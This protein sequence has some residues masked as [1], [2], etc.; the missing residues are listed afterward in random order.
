MSKESAGL[1][2][3][4]VALIRM[5]VQDGCKTRVLLRSRRKHQG[6]IGSLGNY[7]S[8]SSSFPHLLRFGFLLFVFTTLTAPTTTVLH[9]LLAPGRLNSGGLGASAAP[10]QASGE[11]QQVTV[12]PDTPQNLTTIFNCEDGDFEVSWVGVV[13]LPQTIVI[14]HG[15]TVSITGDISRSTINRDSAG[16]SKS[17]KV[18]QK[19]QEFLEGRS[20]P[21]GLTSAAVGPRPQ[22]ATSND[23]DL[24]FGPIF[25]VDGGQLILQGVGVRNGF[26]TNSTNSLVASG[27]GIYAKDSNV[28]IVGCEFEN[29]FAEFW[30]G[31]IFVNRATLVVVDSVFSGCEAGLQAFA[32]DRDVNERGGCIGVSSS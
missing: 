19:L 22:N 1:P 15:T 26:A 16:I 2:G 7:F 32:G 18:D 9:Q 25:F 8:S 30:G 12:T 28:T 31:G 24:S 5:G 21:G 10:C 4:R 29:N 27:G 23:G 17:S 14:G 3:V 20:L 6:Y 11:V 13:N